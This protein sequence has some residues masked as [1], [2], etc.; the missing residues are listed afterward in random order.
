[1]YALNK[2]LVQQFLKSK[3]E[4]GIFSGAA[5]IWGTG[6]TSFEEVYVGTLQFNSRSKINSRTRFDIQSITKT[7]STVPILTELTK[8]KRIRLDDPVQKHLPDF[9]GLGKD[10]VLIEDLVN[11]TSGLSDEDLNFEWTSVDAAWESQL[12]SQLRFVPKMAIEYGDLNYRIL[13][14]LVEHVTQMP[15][16]QVARELV[17]EKYN[18][19]EATYGPFADPEKSNIAGG[20][21]NWG[22][23]DD[24]QDQLL[25]GKVGCDGLFCSADD[26]RKYLIDLTVNKENLEWIADMMVDVNVELPVGNFYCS[27]ALG[28]KKLGWEVHSHKSSYAP[29]IWSENL[30]EKAG[31]G[32][33]FIALNPVSQQY[34]I[35]LTNF[36]RPDPFTE[37]TWNKL[38]K[39]IDPRKASSIAF[40]N[41]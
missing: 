16:D 13:G 5:V 40:S 10:R 1:M 24:L 8:Q 4:A 28:A 6:S 33:A 9:R 29:A 11:H 27:L 20:P 32:G 2:N 23:V 19:S 31:G 25:G 3:I 18:M 41:P 38:V 37:D 34:F 30:I 14:K 7:L 12:N 26:L 15:L 22:I 35:Y 36:G 17:F 21:K 39:E